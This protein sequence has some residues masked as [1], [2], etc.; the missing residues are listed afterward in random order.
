MNTS[1]I[2]VTVAH[3][4]SELDDVP[5]VRKSGFDSRILLKQTPVV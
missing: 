5:P 3:K 4:P 1:R 2:S